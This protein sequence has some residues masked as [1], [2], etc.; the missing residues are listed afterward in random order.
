MGIVTSALRVRDVSGD[1][2]LVSPH[3]SLAQW[4]RLTCLDQIFRI[5]ESVEE[6]LDSWNCVERN[7]HF[8]GLGVEEG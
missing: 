4:L 5:F 2:R 6:A 7:G 1:I 3:H 8:V